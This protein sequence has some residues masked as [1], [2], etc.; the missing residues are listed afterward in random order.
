MI[1][2]VMRLSPLDDRYELELLT[3]FDSVS[4]AVVLAMLLS[5]IAQGLLAGLGYY[6]AF[7]LLS[8]F[9]DAS[10]GTVFLAAVERAAMAPQ[11]TSLP[12]PS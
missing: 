3:E 8:P 4:R 7:F 11:C 1:R 10:L 2:A 9:P 12:A 5:A 6:L